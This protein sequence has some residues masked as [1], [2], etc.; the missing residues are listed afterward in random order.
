MIFN[1]FKRSIFEIGHC[2]PEI[3]IISD[4]FYFFDCLKIDATQNVSSTRYIIYT[5]THTYTF[6]LPHF[7]YFSPFRSVCICLSRTLILML[8]FS[9]PNLILIHRQCTHLLG[10]CVVVRLFYISSQNSY[11]LNDGLFCPHKFLVCTKNKANR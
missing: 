9:F 1:I 10:L 2:W 6:S 8:F 7:P 4:S 5:H 3:R 11:K